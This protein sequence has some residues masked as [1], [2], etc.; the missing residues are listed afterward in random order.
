MKKTLFILALSILGIS[1]S[2]ASGSDVIQESQADSTIISFDKLIHDFGT[3]EKGGDGT[4]TFTFTNKGIQPLG[5]TSVKTSC[6]CTTPFWPKEPIAPG[7]TGE[8]KIK[9]DT[10]RMGA[11]NKSITVSSNA[12][13][14]VLRIKGTIKA[15]K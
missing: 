12:E 5:L 13:T 11:F 6:G 8:I 7:K 1:M 14:V 4:Y 2:F 3:I 15:A 10:N 9:Y